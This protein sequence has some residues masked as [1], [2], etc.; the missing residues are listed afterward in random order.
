VIPEASFERAAGAVVLHAV[1]GQ[2]MALAG[3]LNAELHV[4]FA[5]GAFQPFDEGQIGGAAA[6]TLGNMDTPAMMSNLAE[7]RLLEA[8][9]VASGARH[10]L[11]IGTFTGV[12]ALTMAAA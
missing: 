3:E 11:E 12:G 2:D 8:L 5:R 7:A 4:D 1:T 6:W 10:V 9:I